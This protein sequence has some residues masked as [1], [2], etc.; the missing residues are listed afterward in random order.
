MNRTAFRC[1]RA[2]FTFVEVVVALGVIL[3]IAALLLAS[4]Q[5]ASFEA[6][7]ARCMGNLRTIAVLFQSYQADH[8]MSYPFSVMRPT[9]TSPNYFWAEALVEHSGQSNVLSAFI[10]PAVKNIN[11][12]LARGVGGYAY[13]S[14]AINRYGVSPAQGDSYIPAR[15]TTMQ[16]ASQ[17]LLLLDFDTPGQPYD[18]WYTATR[19]GA[20]NEWQTLLKRHQSINGLFCDGHVQRLEYERDTGGADSAFPWK[21]YVNLRRP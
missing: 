2:A 13:V 19:Q 17:V 10:C 3:V 15:K 20:R 6:T 18:G 4:V 9:P 7:S 14:Y 16:D 11:P 5:T 1:Q 12:D 21:S 8:Q